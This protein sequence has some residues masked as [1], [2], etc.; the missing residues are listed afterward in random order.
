MVCD[1]FHPNVGG[2]ESH[3]YMLSA[4]L[5]KRGHRVIV[6]THS[7]PPDRVGIRWLL[8]G[9]KVYYVPFPTI[10]SSATLPN[11]LTFLPYLRTIV[12]REGVE[13]IHAHAS[14]S[15]LGHEG[16]L[17]AHHMGVRTVFT[18]HSLFGFD[19]AASILTNKLLEA[20]LRN[21]DAAICVSHTGR[22][23]TVLRARLPPECVYVIP[24][25]LVADQFKP[26]P[27]AKK[28]NEVT[29][30]VISR[31]AY[32]KGIDLLVATAPR[33]CA[34]FPNVKFVIG[35]DAGADG[36]K[37]I[38][39]LQMREKH[40][41]QDRI[42]MLGSVRHS[43]VP[44]VRRA[45]PGSIFL[46]TSLTES[47]GIAILEAACAGLYVVATRV[48]GVPE[49]L[50]DDMMSFAN[51]D[52]DDVVRAMAEAIDI[53]SKGQHD[54][55]R[56][57]ARVKQFYDWAQIAERTERVYSNV[58]R[59]RPRSFWVRLQRTLEL[60]RFAGPIFTIILLVDCLFFAFLEWWIPRGTIDKVQM[61]WDHQ[62]FE[63]VWCCRGRP[64][65]HC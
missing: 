5:I 18:D 20:A 17:H 52:E 3:I 37:M 19:D 32:R 54:P 65:E 7:H 39:L 14:L 30:V 28:T 56:A 13:L 10:A 29:I 38:D 12:L 61:H 53:V 9:L 24:N 46:N 16:I 8:P 26:D 23:N 6:I 35:N 34:L 51:P 48:G 40:T 4:N 33:I 64:L 44:D 58:M 2:V 1:F 59:T 11:F 57:H 41:L 45:N 21:V 60:G 47:F 43:D 49:I 55:A 25:A 31:L 27:N 50:P 22:E 15:A 36:P 63:E 62:R 42:E